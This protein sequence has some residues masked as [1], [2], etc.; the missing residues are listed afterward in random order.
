MLIDEQWKFV[1]DIGKLITKAR[2]LGY[3]LTF[4]EAWRTPVQAWINALP[5]N[6][7]LKAYAL[8]G[9]EIDYS[10]FVGGV[11]ISKSK[12][13]DRFA[14]DFNVFKNGQLC[15]KDETK[16]L[17]DYWETLSDKNRWGGNFTTRIDCPH[18]ERNI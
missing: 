13:L 14:V 9:S 17:G 12:H 18:F 10:T 5:H 1:L 6:S 15:G 3:T 16:P 8:D 2:E 7:H 11:G 4:G